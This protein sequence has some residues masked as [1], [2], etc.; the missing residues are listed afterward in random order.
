MS[1][2]SKIGSVIHSVRRKCREQGIVYLF[3]IKDQFFYV[4]EYPPT[5]NN[6]YI[7]PTG[8]VKK[9]EGGKKLIP[10]GGT[11]KCFK[12]VY[13]KYPECYIGCYNEDLISQDVREDIEEHISPASEG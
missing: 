4:S 3:Y 2:R 9:F 7:L 12:D 10:V 11:L 1:N 8:Y 6:K 5:S 13:E